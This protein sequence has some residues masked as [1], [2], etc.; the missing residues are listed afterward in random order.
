MQ[1]DYECENN[2]RLAGQTH[3]DNNNLKL[4]FFLF[5]KPDNNETERSVAIA[6]FQRDKGDILILF[7]HF[8]GVFI[9]VSLLYET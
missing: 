1:S 6:L 8:A 2:N 7:L 3:T 9:F 4:L 5:F